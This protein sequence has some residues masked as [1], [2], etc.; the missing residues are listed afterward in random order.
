MIIGLLDGRVDPGGNSR[1]AID[2]P[3]HTGRRL[4]NLDIRALVR[5]RIGQFRLW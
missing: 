1:G 4:R 5:G 3:A 2:A